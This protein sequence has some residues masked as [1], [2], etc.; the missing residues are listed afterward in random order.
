MQYTLEGGENNRPVDH[1]ASRQ[2]RLV[3]ALLI[4]VLA[5]QKKSEK[6]IDCE[7]LGATRRLCLRSAA[8]ICCFVSFTVGR[9][10]RREQDRANC[11]VCFLLKFKRHGPIKMI[12]EQE[13]NTEM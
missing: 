1:S 13:N 10:K 2:R 3:R 11:L 4:A 6:T 9:T 12:S 5:K 7:L 8:I